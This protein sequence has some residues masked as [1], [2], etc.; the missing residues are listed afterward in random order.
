MKSTVSCMFSSS[1]IE[2]QASDVYT[3]IVFFEVQK[4]L[5][6]SI[7]ACGWGDTE[8]VEAAKAAKVKAKY[9]FRLLGKIHELEEALRE[10][11]AKILELSEKFDKFVET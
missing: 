6:K 9:M 7:C 3:H 11:N 2:A 4:E 8:K 1:R 5:E 10:S